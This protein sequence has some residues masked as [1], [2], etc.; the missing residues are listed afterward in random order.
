MF[1]KLFDKSDASEINRLE[2]EKY[3]WVV[4]IFLGIANIFGDEEEQEY[5]KTKNRNLHNHAKQ[6]F[7]FSLTISILIY[8]Y[9]FTRNYTFYEQA[10]GKKK[11]EYF[12]NLLGSVLLISAAFC[13]LY[14]ETHEEEFEGTPSI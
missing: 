7:T 12:I 9:Y 14:F 10:N 13:F 1:D 4:L 3:V 5:I 8:I 2:F 11:Q 6:I